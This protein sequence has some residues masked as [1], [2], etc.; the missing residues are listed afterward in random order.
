MK[1]TSLRD[2]DRV[3][4]ADLLRV[5]L[6]TDKVRAR[7]PTDLLVRLSDVESHVDDD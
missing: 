6:I 3:H 1:L 2:I 5:G 7:L 4:V